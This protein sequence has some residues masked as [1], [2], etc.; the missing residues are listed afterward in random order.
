MDHD[1]VWGMCQHPLMSILNQKPYLLRLDRNK[2]D[3]GNKAGATKYQ[4]AP[5]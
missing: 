2:A 5:A 1:L 4:V 3:M